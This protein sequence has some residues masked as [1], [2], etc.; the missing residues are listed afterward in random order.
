MARDSAASQGWVVVVIF[1]RGP[2]GNP[3][4]DYA[5]RRGW[6]ENVHVVTD[7]DALIRLV[8]AGKV[9]IVLASNLNGLGRSLYQLVRVLRDFV[10]HK[11]A[12]IIPSAGIDT[13]KV[14][15]KVILDTLDAIE[16]LKREA[17]REGINEGLAHAKA[18]GVRLG[19]PRKVNAYRDDV[20]RLRAQGLTGRAIAKDL[21][22][23]SSNVF[24]LIADLGKAALKGPREVDS[25]RNRLLGYCERQKPGVRLKRCVRRIISARPPI[26]RGRGNMGG[27]KSAKPRG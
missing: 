23:P 16:E 24:R 22:I 25:A 10:A 21:R 15:G 1:A 14:P 18:R 6:E 3:L 26:M 27:W 19:R 2:D 9:E 13:S 20:A 7:L 11:V 5:V 12:L 17:T 4:W 8:W